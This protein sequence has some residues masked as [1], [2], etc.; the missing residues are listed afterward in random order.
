LG[1]RECSIQRRHQKVVEEAPSPFLDEETR[2][3]MGEQAVLLARTV[4][5]TSA[6]TVEFI[7]DPQRNFYFL[8]MNTRLQVEHP[9]TEFVTGLDLVE[10]MIRIAAGERLSMRQEDIV[11]NG[12]SIEARVYAED[13]ARNFLPSI[14]RLVRY[15]P[16]AATGNIRIDTG[17]REGGEVS[18]FYDPMMAKVITH[19]RDRAE[20]I[21]RMGVA[22]DS[23]VVEGVANNLGFLSNLMNHPRFIDG[24]LSTGF[25]A[26]EYPEGFH[27]D[28]AASLNPTRIT[29]IAAVVH[30]ANEIRC[31]QISRQISDRAII[32]RTEW[33]V[34]DGGAQRT[35]RTM[36]VPGGWDVTV[37]DS[38]MVQIRSEWRV[39]QGVFTANVSGETMVVSIGSDGVDYLLTYAGVVSR[40]QVLSPA[41]AQLVDRMPKKRLVDRS[42]L[43]LSPMP[44][45]L[46]SLAVTLGQEVRAG[47]AL[48]VVEAMKMENVLRAERD[49]VVANLHAIPGENLSVDQPILEFIR[50]DSAA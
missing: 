24:R 29:A 3:A 21:Q 12:W 37:A 46:V 20:A 16:P 25:I 34:I 22:L 35:T 19:G 4:G 41:I 49:G 26:A 14:G 13:P 32:V 6:G 17:V 48:A 36:A 1:E 8:E 18:V 50:K 45:L 38:E 40:L 44:G 7:V 28:R 30:Y 5:Y 10:Q 39:G 15:A 27:P 43:V 42:H 47:E 9:V 31:A 33:V 11:L 2:R 23:F